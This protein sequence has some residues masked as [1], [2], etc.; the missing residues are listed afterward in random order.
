MA[1]AAKLAVDSSADAMQMADAMFGNGIAVQSASYIGAASAKGIYSN[2]DLVAPGLTPS[3]SGVILS[4]GKA[5]DVTNAAG[6]ANVS[7]GTTTNHY[8]QGD[9][10]LSQVSG[11]ETFDAAVFEA[12]FIPEG[13]TLTMQVVFSSEE[14]LEFTNSGFNDAV[15]VWVNG[16]SATLTVG[17][18]DITINNINDTSN[19]NLYIDNPASAET[20]NTEMD[21]FT[22]TLTLK[23]PVVPG[24]VN[25]IKIGIADGGDAAYDSNLLIAGNSIQTALIAGDDAVSMTA[26]TTAQIDVLANDVSATGGTLTITH[27]N[28]QAVAVGDTITLATGEQITLTATGFRLAIDAEEAGSNTFSYNVVD[29]LGN[30]DVAFVTVT[31]SVPCFAAGTLV[32]TPT[33]PRPV[34]RILVG[35]LVMTLDHGARPVRWIGK[36]RLS[37]NELAAMP[38]LRPIRIARGAL[39]AGRPLADLL[40]SPQH[41][42]LVRSRIAR[43]MFDA[44]E[45]LVAAKQLLGMPGVTQDS[46]AQ[47][48]TYVH[49]LFDRHE[50]VLSNGAATESL[51]TGAEAVKTIEP[52]AL[53]EIFAIFPA[54]RA[55]QPVRPFVQGKAARQLA[56]R[57]QRND[58][59]LQ[60]L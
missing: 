37:G 21:G 38:A 56:A 15:G 34:E 39:G 26:G 42:V 10:D 32:A 31:T 35:D 52:A 23:A 6:D 24:Q 49:L 47:S 2:G 55:P 43:R 40:L 36:R 59:A 41:R 53:A 20:H 46:G 28:G 3:D 16:V 18:G 50:L 14:Y 12:T 4:T 44:D 13:S 27:I 60:A 8:R 25:T 9:D 11:H 30:S 51:F 7:A 1:V 45:V 33:G 19:A 54:L 48:V 29:D 5:A 22:V 57:H 17:T 58:V